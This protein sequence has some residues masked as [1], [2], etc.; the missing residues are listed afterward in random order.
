[1]PEAELAN[2]FARGALK[3]FGLLPL[4]SPRA[5]HVLVSPTALYYLTST[6]GTVPSEFLA[7]VWV[8]SCLTTKMY[9]RASVHGRSGSSCKKLGRDWSAN[10]C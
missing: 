5:K 9:A 1:M 6:R 2:V 7:K 4:A 8:E 3:T 10:R